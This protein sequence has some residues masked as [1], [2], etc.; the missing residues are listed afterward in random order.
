[1]DSRAIDKLKLSKELKEKPVIDFLIEILD[2]WEKVLG[3]KNRY[4][5]PTFELIAK[6]RNKI[7]KV[8][9]VKL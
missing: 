2:V 5:I 4:S 8:I 1:M 6:I 9:D 7:T 3:R